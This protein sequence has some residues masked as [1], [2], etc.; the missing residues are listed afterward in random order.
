M[1][2]FAFCVAFGP[3]GIYLLVLGA[4]NLAR[5]PRM[6]SGARDSAA[7]ALALAGFVAVGPM[8]LFMPQSAAARYGVWVWAMLLAGYV[9]AVGLGA[10]LAAPRLVVYNCDGG[11]M[12]SLLAERAAELDPASC[13]AGDCLSMP[14]LGVQ[15]RC[16]DFAALRNV[17]LVAVG[18][19]Q[20]HRGW[21]QLERALRSS[22]GE[23]DSARNPPGVTMVGVGLL[24]LAA[25]VHRTL[26]NPQAIAESF[27]DL[28]R[29]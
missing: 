5:R 17:S 22:L 14:A 9:L 6:V 18:A 16:Q 1:R 15:L 20:S 19:A 25:V 2:A 23:L 24:I 26:D 28:L 8:E 7:L 3:V 27:F 29:L 13:W 4:I 11:Q 21:R 10:L 12:R